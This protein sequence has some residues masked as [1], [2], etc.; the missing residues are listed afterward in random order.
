VRL[1]HLRERMECV[2]C[3][4]RFI[5]KKAYNKHVGGHGEH[6]TQME[7]KG[8]EETVSKVE[9]GEGIG[10]DIYDSEESSQQRGQTYSDR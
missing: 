5:K 3:G 10:E 9:L 4:M 7:G 1:I 8:K 2:V 6:S